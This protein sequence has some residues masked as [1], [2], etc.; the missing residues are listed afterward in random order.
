MKGR[1]IRSWLDE[2]R[3]INSRGRPIQPGDILILVRTRNRFFDAVIREDRSILDFIDG[4]F[5]FLNEPLAKLYGNPD[6]K[7]PAFSRVELTGEE[8]S[9]VLTQASVLAVSS[10]PT[11]TSPV[12]FS[13]S[14]SR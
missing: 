13:R 1:T 10:Y 12:K 9:G 7:G 8:R 4:K 2:K 14:S 11:R 3:I 5:T 6:V